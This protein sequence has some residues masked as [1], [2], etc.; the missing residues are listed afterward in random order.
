MANRGQYSNCP[1]SPSSTK[2]RP[3]TTRSSSTIDI[4]FTNINKSYISIYCLYLASVK[5]SHHQYSHGSVRSSHTILSMHCIFI[6]PHVHPMPHNE[7]DSFEEVSFSSL[8]ASDLYITISRIPIYKYEPDYY[9]SNFS[10]T[11][12]TLCRCQSNSLFLLI[13][14]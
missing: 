14:C 6:P 12:Y 4:I 13:D 7:F 1:Q 3:N 11:L 8:S 5:A 2:P 10:L 9:I